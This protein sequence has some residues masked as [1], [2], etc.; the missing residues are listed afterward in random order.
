[1]PVLLTEEAEFETWLTG[2]TTEAMGLVKSYDPARM[3]M[4]QS[5]FAKEDQLLSPGSGDD[6]R[7]ESVPQRRLL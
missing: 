7:T 5:G 2:S 1:M 6:Q 4:V 3:R